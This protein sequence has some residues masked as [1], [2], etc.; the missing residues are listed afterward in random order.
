MIPALPSYGLTL[1]FGVA[2][3]PAVDVG[4]IVSFTWSRSAWHTFSK[5]CRS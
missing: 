2:D 4:F 1:I 5:A 3:L